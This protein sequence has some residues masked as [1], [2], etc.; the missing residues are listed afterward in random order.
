[1]TNHEV[2][3][4]ASRRYPRGMGTKTPQTSYEEWLALDEKVRAEF[5]DG[6]IVTLPSPSGPHQYVL[7]A[8]AEFI[9]IPFC[10]RHGRGGPGDWWILPDYDVCFGEQILRPDLVGWRR[11][12]S[13]RLPERPVEL[14]PDWVC[15]IVSPSN[16]NHDRVTKR[17]LY[18]EHGV[19]HYWVVDPIARTLDALALRD[20]AWVE[21][22]VYD[23]D[24]V[25]RIAPFDAVELEIGRLFVPREEME[26]E[27]CVATPHGETVSP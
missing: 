22:G 13:P 21:I 26:E 16:T 5:I 11:E 18:A 17:R 12:R 4:G 14:T 3:P 2:T 20:G 24:D 7:N 27:G 6:R 23:E 15:E 8:L 25:A 19:P 10:T 9:V 1:M